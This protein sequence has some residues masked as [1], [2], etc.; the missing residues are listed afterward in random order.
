M[1]ELH[2]P[3]A[4]KVLAA[5]SHVEDPDLKRDLVTLG[6]IK[7]L[8]ITPGVVAFTVE[9]TTP[10]CP[11]KDAIHQ[12]C[13][14]AV[15]HLVDQSLEVQVKMTAR[16]T[17]NTAGQGLT[18]PGVKNIIGVASGKGGVGKSTIAANLAVGLAESGARVGLLDADIYG[19]SVPMMFGAKRANAPEI[20]ERDGKNIIRPLMLHG[21]LVMS[22]GLLMD[23]NQAVA[24]RGPMA[25]SALKQF[26]NDVEWGELDYLIVD[27]P[28]GTGDVHITLLTSLPVRGVVLVT[29]PQP[30]A[31][32]DAKKAASMLRIPQLNTP[33]LGV[34]E[35]MAWFTPAELPEHRYFLFGEGGGA[36]LAK[37]LEVP[38]L[39][40]VPLV[41]SVRESGD[42]GKPALLTAEVN[43]ATV[44]L[45]K[46]AGEVARQVSILNAMPS[47]PATTE[48][49]SPQVV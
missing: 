42:K 41:Q 40:Q 4:E 38:L 18:L 20:F 19:P 37:A 16:T 11:M 22:I 14:N 10:A 29:T 43:P 7:D 46:M 5:L 44:A 24:W 12:A 1:S 39:A 27:L 6:M 30:V 35:N 26:I 23:E 2:L 48:L 47:S 8:V 32:A 3:T 28:P 34:V 31:L 17:T 49:N 21:V 33:I 15:K 9:L 13:V 25:T 45:R 36:E